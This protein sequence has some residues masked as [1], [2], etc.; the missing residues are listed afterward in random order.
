MRIVC[1]SDAHDLTVPLPPGDLLVHAGDLTGDGDAE[2]IQAQLDWLDAQPHRHQV[3]VAG[4][5]DSWFDPAARKAADHDAG[6]GLD[7]KSVRY[8]E[9]S[10][11]AL[12]FD[13]GRTLNV[14]G[15][16]D[17]PQCGGSSFA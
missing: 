8:L 10:A 14:Y 6:A 7:F 9:R 4:N 1:I 2:D 3:A 11:V 12:E 16:P 17:L 13:G 15:A 5:H